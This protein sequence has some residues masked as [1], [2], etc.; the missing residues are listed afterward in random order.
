MSR[1]CVII[2]GV[3]I[4]EWIYWPLI[5]DTE[6]QV[7]TA[8]PLISTLYKSP[9]QPLSILQP[10]V[11]SPAVPWQRLLTVEI[12]QL[13][14]LRSFLHSPPYRI[15]C[16]LNWTGS[17]QLSS[18]PRYGPRRKYRSFSQANRFHGNVFA[19]PITGCVRQSIK[20]PL[21]QQRPSFHDR[22]PATGI[23][24]ILLTNNN[25]ETYYLSDDWSSI[26]GRGWMYI[27]A[28]GPSSLLSY[29]YWG[30]PLDN[31]AET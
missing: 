2:G 18:I 22:Y 21:P 8:P 25:K 26:L 4:G 20:N 24:A 9:Q 28:L 1:V 30:F 19:S 5:H 15:P 11:S 6:L 7:I 29:G 14:A 17:P 13:H 23:H 10:T 27:I 16:Q 12:L 3:W 31:F